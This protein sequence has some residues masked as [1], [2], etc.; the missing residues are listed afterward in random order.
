MNR[1]QQVAG[2]FLGTVLLIG[3]S[4]LYLKNHNVNTIMNQPSQ[5]DL[6]SNLQNIQYK[7]K[8]DKI[9]TLQV[10]IQ[11]GSHALSGVEYQIFLQASKQ[12]PDQTLNRL[13]A[14]ISF[15]GKTQKLVMIQHIKKPLLLA[16]SKGQEKQYLIRVTS[17]LNENVPE[18]DLHYLLTSTQEVHVAIDD[19]DTQIM[20]L[21]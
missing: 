3:L 16:S 9:S 12:I 19:G 11:D 18:E 1:F 7:I 21:K 2:F 17:T 8:L 15:S 13:Q 5:V 6:T 14:D 4:S 20:N 10:N